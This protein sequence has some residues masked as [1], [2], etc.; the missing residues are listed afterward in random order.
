MAKIQNKLQSNAYNSIIFSTF[1]PQFCKLTFNYLFRQ[2]ESI[3]NRFHF[4]SRFV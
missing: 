1:A 2:Y 4:D 3:R